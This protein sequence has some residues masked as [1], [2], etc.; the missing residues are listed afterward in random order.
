MERKLVARGM[1]AGALAGLLAFLFARI[2][3]EPQIQAAV[4]YENGRDAAL[5]HSPDR[6]GSDVFSRTVQ[7]NLGL[8][9]GMVFFGIAMG[10]LFAVVYTVC[11][12]RVG[13]LRP[14]PLALLVAG[15]GFLALYLIPFLKYPANPP[16]IGDPDTIHR[17]GL[18][19]LVMVACSVTFLAGAVWLGRQLQPRYG[20]W[21][22]TLLAGLAFVVATGALMAALPAVHETPSPLH[23]AAGHLVY[24]G[25]PADT[26]AAFRLYSVGAQLLLWTA[27]GLA[28]APLAD[29]VLTPVPA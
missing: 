28:F 23:D 17:R 15:A 1:L 12:G 9:V 16:A 11:L 2:L 10:L 6:V 20:A 14:R 7:A 29:R 3:A 8:G 13:A 25:F 4:D 26:L 24:P 19:Y 21:N 18:L 22:A 27:L 5:T